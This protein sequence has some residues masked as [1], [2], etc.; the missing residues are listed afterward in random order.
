MASHDTLV[1]PQDRPPSSTAQHR[2]AQANTHSTAQH[3][4]GLSHLLQFVQAVV[5]YEAHLWG[6]PQT[7]GLTNARP[8]IPNSA[9]QHK[10]APTHQQFTAHSTRHDLRPADNGWMCALPRR[11]AT[12]NHGP[13][14]T[15]YCFEHSYKLYCKLLLLLN[16]GLTSPLFT[17][18]TTEQCA[19][20][21]SSFSSNKHSSA[22]CNC[23]DN[24][25]IM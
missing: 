18:L 22:V 23:K 10:T 6:Q 5:L 16:T 9:R 1:Q 11:A 19:Q 25:N 12:C 7:H 17:E 21:C 8:H 15:H 2:T 13:V 20:G 4:P 14:L 24:C 3:S